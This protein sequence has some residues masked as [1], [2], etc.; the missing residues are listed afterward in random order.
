MEEMLRRMRAERE[1]KIQDDVD[2]LTAM[3]R[4][5]EIDD[6]P[7]PSAVPRIS[8]E[9][10]V[11]LEE[12]AAVTPAARARLLVEACAPPAMLGADTRLRR[13]GALRAL[14]SRRPVAGP[15]AWAP[16]R[17]DHEVSAT[18]MKTA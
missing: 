11:R 6:E 10:R 4:R 17:P 15:A 12:T 7:L 5:V 16:H 8:A 2:R 18:G 14:L 1:A 9:E 13:A 3:L